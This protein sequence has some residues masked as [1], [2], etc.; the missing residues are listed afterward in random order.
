MKWALVATPT[1][2]E[3]VPFWDDADD[4]DARQ[5]ATDN[6]CVWWQWGLELGGGRVV[7]PVLVADRER[8][9]LPGRV[10]AQRP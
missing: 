1:H 7:D 9:L 4:A 8:G 2:L 5:W 6:R 3:T 10:V